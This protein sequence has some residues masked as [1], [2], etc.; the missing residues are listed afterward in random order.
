[1]RRQEDTSAI[2]EPMAEGGRGKSFTFAKM[3]ALWG[4]VERLRILCGRELQNSIK[5]SFHAELK[6]AIASD[7]WLASCYDVGIDYI[8][9]KNGTEFIFRG[10][11]HNMDSIKSMAQIDLCIVEEA[12]TVPETS[13]QALLPTIRSPK[14]EVWIIWN[15]MKKGSATDERFKQAQPPRSAIVEVNW[16][17]NPW[18]PLELEEQ[19][20]HDKETMEYAVYNNIWEGR[21]AAA[22]KGAYYGDLMTKARDEGRI[23]HV[24]Y[25]PAT[26]VNTFWD[27]GMNDQMTIWFHQQVGKEHRFIDYYENSG[28]GF[29]HYAKVLKELDYLYGTHYLPHDA[30]VRELATGKHRKEVLESL[31]VRPIEVVKRIN[32]INEGIEMVRQILPL[33]WFDEAKCETGIEALEGYRREFDER[34]NTFKPRPLHDWASHA[35]DSFRQFAQGYRGA[36]V[37][38]AAVNQTQTTRRGRKKVQL[39]GDTSWMV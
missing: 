24:P 23:I 28:E 37:G 31:G 21:Y 33:C 14:S 15:P 11:R 35:A 6:N 27:L 32:H 16:S 22:L 30:E 9:G 7:P 34:L 36:N 4:A 10:F 26:P 1:M 29:A 20:L 39:N 18:F 17:D 5:D 8:R 19:R 2:A 12:E 38:W 13:W 25:D 3:A